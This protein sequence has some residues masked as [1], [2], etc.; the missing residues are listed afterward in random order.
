[1]RMNDNEEGGV[2]M[3]KK[4]LV[5]CLALT[6]GSISYGDQLGN[7]EG[8]MDGWVVNAGTGAYSTDSRVVTLGS[9]ALAMYE[10]EGWIQEL[11][12]AYAW[13]NP[14]R[15]RLRFGGTVTIDVSV[16]AEEWELGSALDSAGNETHWG[17]K[18]LENLIIQSNTNWWQ[19]LSP[20]VQPN[21]SGDGTRDGVYKPEDGDKQFTYTF[22]LPVQ[23]GMTSDMTIW[24]ICNR[25]AVDIAG[26]LYYDN[27]VFTI[28]EPATIAMLGLG[29]LALIRRKK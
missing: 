29:G 1:M 18:P 26:A 13:N 7:W 2:D 24:M 28:P 11:Q 21:F 9:Q 12:G 22:T 8:V 15:D 14:E 16:L 5:I 25:G 6:M 3:C 20:V 10:G 17:I 4:L 19:Q 23:T 27:M